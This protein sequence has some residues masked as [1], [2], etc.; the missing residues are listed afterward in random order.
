MPAQTAGPA[1]LGTADAG[2]GEFDLVRSTA[3]V[4][5]GTVTGSPLTGDPLLGPLGDNGGPTRTMVPA[6]GSPAIDAGAAFGLTTDQRGQARPS[7]FFSIA[8]TGDA[9]DI[10]AVE[11]QSPDRPPGGGG[12]QAFGAKTLVTLRLAVKRIAA[13]GPLPIVVS[14]ANGFPISGAVAGRTTKL[15]S[16][17]QRRRARLKLKRKRF[18]VGARARK[19]VKLKLSRKLRRVLKRQ[20]KLSLRL[21]ATV[22]APAGNSRTVR[23]TVSPKLQK[24]RRR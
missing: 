10:G 22:R 17:A 2:L 20:G 5:T 18:Q 9:S 14:N 1:N 24:K 11:L 19:T 4:G 16:G 21:T 7:D 8:N 12:A 23:K 6:T 3:V 13:E 15:V